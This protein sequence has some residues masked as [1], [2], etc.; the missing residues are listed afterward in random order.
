MGCA[1]VVNAPCTRMITGPAP[2]RS[3]TIAVPSAE[4]TRPVAVPLIVCVL[5][6]RPDRAT[7]AAQSGVRYQAQRLPVMAIEIGEPTLIPAAA[8]LWGACGAGAGRQGLLD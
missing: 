7:L 6:C 8:L 2:E 5:P 4:I 1:L 3:K